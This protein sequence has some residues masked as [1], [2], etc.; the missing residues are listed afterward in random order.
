MPIPSREELPPLL[1]RSP[2]AIID[3]SINFLRTQ[4]RTLFGIAFIILLPLRLVAALLPGSSLRDLRPDQ[5]ADIVLSSF[6]AFSSIV[7]TVVTFVGDSLAVLVVGVIYGKLMASWFSGV[8]LTATDVL[9]WSVKRSPVLFA[10]WFVIHILELLSGIF[11]GGLGLALAVFFMVAAP[12]MGA[13]NAGIRTAFSRSAQLVSPRFFPSLIVF[14]LV[15]VGG[16]AMRFV[17]RTVPTLIGIQLPI[18]VWIVSGVFD[19]IAATFVV[20]FTAASAVVHYL[21]LRVRKEGID[22]EVAMNRVFPKPKA[23]HG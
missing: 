4:P 13:E 7:A 12:V 22:L 14:V 19:L 1:E 18:P 15:G 17:L 20:A 3:E 9:A 10:L 11:T 2:L 16:Q 23:H 6:G 8:G 21:D 5:I